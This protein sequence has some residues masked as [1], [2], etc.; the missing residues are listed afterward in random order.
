MM[1]I[2]KTITTYKVVSVQRV[3]NRVRTETNRSQNVKRVP[4]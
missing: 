2:G 1:C 4:V 3:E